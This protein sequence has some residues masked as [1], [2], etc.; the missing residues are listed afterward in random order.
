MIVDV[1]AVGTNTV[2]YASGT[3]GT[4]EL[5]KQEFLQLLVTQLSHQDPMD[6]ISNQ[7]FIAQMAQFSSLESMTTMA[8]AYDETAQLSKAA[9]GFGLV[10]SS[11]EGVDENGRRVA[12]V[13]WGTELVN[14]QVMLKTGSGM[15]PL[16]SVLKVTSFDN[17]RSYQMLS[18]VAQLLGQEAKVLIN[19]EERSV[20]IS[21]LRVENEELMIDTGSGAVPLSDLVSVSGMS[22]DESIRALESAEQLLLMSAD[23]LGSQSGGAVSGPVT[24]AVWYMSEPTLIIAG[25]TVPFTHVFRV[26]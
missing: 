1:T 23:G 19:G 22:D 11:I 24:S 9:Q 25:E 3:S 7:D 6:P 10:G 5:G 18:D 13:V 8:E 4:A 14:G 26:H 17:I 16:D 21:G 20:V 2:N 15:V 12:G